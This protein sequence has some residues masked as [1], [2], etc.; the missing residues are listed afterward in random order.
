MPIAGAV[1]GAGDR[2]AERRGIP[3]LNFQDRLP[4]R[5][6]TDERVAADN[7]NSPVREQGHRGI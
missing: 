6:R 5:V 2:E 1:Q 4:R 3:Q 7:E